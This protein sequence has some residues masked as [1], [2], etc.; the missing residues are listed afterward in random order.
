MWQKTWFFFLGFSTFS[1]TFL[2]ASC[3]L[4]DPKIP[5][6]TGMFSDFASYIADFINWYWKS[7]VGRLVK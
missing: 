3:W 4:N 1:P 5:E 6:I 2:A 7:E